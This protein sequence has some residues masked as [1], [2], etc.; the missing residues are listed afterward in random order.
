M[1]GQD[2]VKIF[3]L[4]LLILGAVGML[5]S[6]P[7]IFHLL[8]NREPMEWAGYLVMPGGKK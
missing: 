5:F 1:I 2:Y 4:I 3:L 6:F 8:A 7:V